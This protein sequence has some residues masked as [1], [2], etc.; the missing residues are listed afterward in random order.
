[1]ELASHDENSRQLPVLKD[2]S[3]LLKGSV[4]VKG[5]T[6]WI[7]YKFLKQKTEEISIKRIKPNMYE[8]K[9]MLN[10]PNFEQFDILTTKK[11]C[12]KNK[13]ISYVQNELKNILMALS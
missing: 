11:T 1:M 2:N 7:P 10:D 5:K 6:T 9:K 12:V 13:Q 8:L 3:S 4:K